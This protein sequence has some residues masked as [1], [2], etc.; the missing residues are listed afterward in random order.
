MRMALW[1]FQQVT[2]MKVD[3]ALVE[4]GEACENIGMFLSDWLRELISNQETQDLMDRLST[5]LSSHSERMQD[6]MQTPELAME[7]V[8]QWV[9]LGM[10]A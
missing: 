5:M 3:L 9:T 1:R 10:L 8:C 6:L 4:F 7:G 2:S